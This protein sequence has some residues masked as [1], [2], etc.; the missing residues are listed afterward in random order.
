MGSKRKFHMETT[1]FEITTW[2]VGPDAPN[3]NWVTWTGFPSWLGP[4]DLSLECFIDFTVSSYFSNP[5]ATFS[6][7]TTWPSIRKVSCGPSSPTSKL[8]LELKN[9][10]LFWKAM[11]GYALGIWLKHQHMA[12]QVSTSHFS[13][14]APFFRSGPCWQSWPFDGRGSFLG[15]APRFDLRSLC[16]G[17]LWRWKPRVAF[18]GGGWT[19]QG[20][21]AGFHR[22]STL[23]T[24]LTNRVAMCVDFGV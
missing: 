24:L 7:G 23:G 12:Q 21:L 20:I 14:Q 13:K 19:E 18:A 6:C 17:A 8:E 10:T 16:R 22:G 4:L 9:W 3:L 2:Q 5:R 15:P 1:K 11:I